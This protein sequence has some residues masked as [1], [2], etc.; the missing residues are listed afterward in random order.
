MNLGSGT[1]DYF[2]PIVTPSTYQDAALCS[3]E[4]EIPDL[5]EMFSFCDPSLPLIVTNHH[6][7][8]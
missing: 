2:L 1:T 7:Q 6:R 5:E 3:A 4:T 8:F